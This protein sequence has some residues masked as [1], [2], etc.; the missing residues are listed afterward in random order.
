MIESDELM[1]GPSGSFPYGI[2][3][4]RVGL[5]E[6]DANDRLLENVRMEFRE[7]GSVLCPDDS[8]EKKEAQWIADNSK[9]VASS[10]NEREQHLYI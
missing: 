5:K 6:H 9:Q 4:G 8:G 7:W 2:L 3:T 10:K 1:D